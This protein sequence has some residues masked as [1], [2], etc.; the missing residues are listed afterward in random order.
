MCPAKLCLKH[1]GQRLAIMT[2]FIGSAGVNGIEVSAL[3]FIQ[4]VLP[5]GQLCSIFF[6]PI[7]LPSFSALGLRIWHKIIKFPNIAVGRPI[8]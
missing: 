5:S 1:Y 7:F 2:Y 3:Y 4:S 6:S 8:H